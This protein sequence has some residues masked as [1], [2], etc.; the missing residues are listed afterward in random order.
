MC[1][2][3]WL[4]DTSSHELESTFAIESKYTALVLL[5]IGFLILV[6]LFIGFLLY[7]KS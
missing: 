7:T 3:V 2:Y 1:V 5:L 6:L 4:S